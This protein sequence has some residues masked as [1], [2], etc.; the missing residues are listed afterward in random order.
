MKLIVYPAG[1]WA[2]AMLTLQR[3]EQISYFLDESAEL[4]QKGFKIGEGTKNVYCPEYIA[5]EDRDEIIVI[6][7]DTKQ[8]DRC[9]AKLESLG[10][11]ENKHFF[12]GWKLDINFYRVF[13][14]HKEWL[15]F[16][17]CNNVD[18]SKYEIRTQKMSTLIPEYPKVASVMDLGC[19]DEKL[20]KYLDP[21][22]KYY[23]M[24][25]VKRNEKT[26]ICDVNKEPLPDIEVDAYFMA[27]FLPY[28][29]DIVNLFKQMKRAKYLIFSVET[30]DFMKLDAVVGKAYGFVVN[31]RQDYLMLPEII[32]VLWECGFA[33]E[34]TIYE[35]KARNVIFC[36]A[37]NLMN[38]DK[39]E[40][41]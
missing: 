10:L 20:R 3:A 4:Q 7:S 8:Y 37:V 29:S 14:K 28:V 22:V 15:D 24:D 38:I 6:I 16:E 19:A 34:K 23:G 27:G 39:K 9:R 41:K 26:L 35:W 40:S 12:N 31:E 17:V 32:N 21:A 25:C 2:R 36:R 5:N 11:I 1:E 33:I 30:Y 13:E 18:F